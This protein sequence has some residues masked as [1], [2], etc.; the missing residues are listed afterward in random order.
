MSSLRLQFSLQKRPVS[1][2]D[3]LLLIGI[4]IAREDFFRKLTGPRDGNFAQTVVETRPELAWASYERYV[5]LVE[6]T[7]SAAKA[8]GVEVIRKA[9]PADVRRLAARFNVITVISHWRSARFREGDVLD[10]PAVAAAMTSSGSRLR[11]TLSKFTDSV[12]NC[13]STAAA[14]ALTLNEAMLSGMP[15]GNR[16]LG[17]RTQF[18]FELLRR[19]AAIVATMPEAFCGG[20]AIEFADGFYEIGEVASAWPIAYDGVTDLTI[21][22]STVLSELI[23][24]RCPHGLV[25]ANEEVTYPEFRLPLYDAIIRLLCRRPQAYEDA[26]FEIRKYLS[27]RVQ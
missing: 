19:R 10:P 12:W 24:R 20:A 27:R 11:H 9:S 15:N 5:Q 1:P 21:C 23:R 16:H 25:L 7:A 6:R 13:E 4:P 8:V 3:C 26:M 17:A 14:L 22:N 18:E 2:R